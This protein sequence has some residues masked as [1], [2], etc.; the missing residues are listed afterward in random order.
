[1][2]ERRN[3]NH[4][5]VWPVNNLIPSKRTYLEQFSMYDCCFDVAALLSEEELE[6]LEVLP[7]QQRDDLREHAHDVTV[8]AIFKMMG[9]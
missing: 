9:V 1:M 7:K 6:Q 3:Q 8:N 4:K 5:C 2:T